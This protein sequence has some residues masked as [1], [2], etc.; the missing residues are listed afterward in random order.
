MTSRPTC[1]QI[2]D[3]IK[4][5]VVGAPARV[6]LVA[7]NSV[8]VPAGGTGLDPSQTSFFQVCTVGWPVMTGM[9]WLVIAEQALQERSTRGL[10]VMQR[11]QNFTQQRGVL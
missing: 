10:T 3:E 9:T 2:R 8:Q 7:P 4:K 1:L 11:S 6:G 5:Y